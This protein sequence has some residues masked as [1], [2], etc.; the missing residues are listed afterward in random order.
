MSGHTYL[1]IAYAKLGVE[2]R[3]K[4][5]FD[6]LVAYLYEDGHIIREETRISKE[7]I[8][9]LGIMWEYELLHEGWSKSLLD[10]ETD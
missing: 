4:I 3:I 5:D 2:R 9:Q 6:D 8:S 10:I 7:G 1:N